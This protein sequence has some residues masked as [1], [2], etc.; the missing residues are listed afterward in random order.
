MKLLL[1][2]SFMA[3]VLLLELV[4]VVVLERSPLT[5]VTHPSL[6]AGGTAATM[7]ILTS[8]DDHEGGGAYWVEWE[9][10]SCGVWGVS[11]ELDIEHIR[12]S[13]SGE[14]VVGISEAA[15]C[16]AQLRPYAAT[17]RQPG[18]RPSGGHRAE[19]TSENASLRKSNFREDP[20][21]ALGC[22]DLSGSPHMV[23][24]IFP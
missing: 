15:G 10:P 12:V 13:S 7:Y 14:E 5:T 4:G 9:D 1:E 2:G 11:G 18:V 19:R 3:M 6:L 20:F 24:T 22:I 16:R 17:T 23:T 21:H 8:D